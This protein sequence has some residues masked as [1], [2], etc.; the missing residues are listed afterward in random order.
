MI[1]I[2]LVG[3][4]LDTREISLH[5]QRGPFKKEMPLTHMHIL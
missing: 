4:F 1:M 3:V 5:T 2:E